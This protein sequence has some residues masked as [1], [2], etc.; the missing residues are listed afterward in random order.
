MTYEVRKY[1]KKRGEI[2][3]STSFV[4]KK[5]REVC[6]SKSLDILNDNYWNANL[7]SR[8]N[9]EQAGKHG[10][11]IKIKSFDV[12]SELGLTTNRFKERE[13]PA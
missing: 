4:T 3:L 7:L 10:C 6:I 11:E 1:I 13:F 12:I 5:S 8:L 2:I 9:R